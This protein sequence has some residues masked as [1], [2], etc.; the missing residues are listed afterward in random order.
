MQQDRKWFGAICAGAILA[1]AMAFPASAGTTDFLGKWTNVDHDTSGIAYVSVKPDPMGVHMR[2]F[3]ACQPTD[4][5]WGAVEVHLY[6][7]SVGGNPVNDAHA[8][9]GHFNSSFA[10]KE[11][12]LREA[13]GDELKYEVYTHFTDG[14]GRSDYVT[15]GR[16]QRVG[17]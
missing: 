17:F 3:G 11:M 8:I 6:A 2:V 1:A 15:F 7:G 14:S 16:L 10:H 13:H 5:D 12:I 4:C 9:I